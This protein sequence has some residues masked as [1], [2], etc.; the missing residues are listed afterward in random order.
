MIPYVYVYVHVTIILLGMEWESIGNGPWGG[1]RV[2]PQN[3]PQNGLHGP[4][5]LF[6]HTTV[7]NI[8]RS[9]SAVHISSFAVHT[10]GPS[11]SRP[12][13]H[14]IHPPFYNIYMRPLMCIHFGSSGLGVCEWCMCRDVQFVVQYCGANS[15]YAHIHVLWCVYGITVLSTGVICLY[16]ER[17]IAD[18]W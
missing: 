11:R 6:I 1:P 8:M 17:Y 4:Q 2:G 13:V 14:H 16:V 15:V 3:G 9:S 5:N 7:H 10:V 12:A 18:K